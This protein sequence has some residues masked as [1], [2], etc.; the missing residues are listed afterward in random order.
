MK[1][2]HPITLT[3]GITLLLAGCSR[4]EEPQS[5][6][7]Q[8]Q[9]APAEQAAAP[10]ILGSNQ[11]R[12]LS[13]VQ[14][15]GYTYVEAET[16]RGIIWLAGSPTEVAVGEIISWSQAAV[17][18][19]F[20]SKTLDRTF[21]EILFVPSFIKASDAGATGA[22]PHA[23][24]TGADPHA[25]A[26][27]S[28][29]APEQGKVLSAKSVSGYT[30]LE[31]E[32]SDGAKLWLASP[33]TTAEAGQ[34]VSWVGGSVMYN[35]ASKTLEKTFPEILFVGGVNIVDNTEKAGVSEA[36]ETPETA[37]TTE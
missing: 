14:V 7:E 16:D 24:I 27:Q 12:V 21:D 28:Q 25:A 32:Q 15:A 19:N 26:P 10:V 29:G 5:V 8:P 1:L 13:S 17:M 37:E 6:A 31:I 9:A 18:K 20:T 35:F 2:T 34:S 23:G 30:Y 11:G 33:S 22:E 4:Q 36:V 3:L